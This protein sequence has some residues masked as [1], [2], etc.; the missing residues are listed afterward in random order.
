M[1]EIGYLR[2]LNNLLWGYLQDEQ[3]R[4]SLVRRA[5]EYDHHYGLALQGKA[6]PALDRPTPKQI[7]G[8]VS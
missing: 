4:L 5:Y 1:L 8:G 6:V 7:P 2:P 3:H